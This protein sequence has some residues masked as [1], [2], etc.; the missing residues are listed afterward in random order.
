MWSPRLPAT[1]T[2]FFLTEH[3]MHPQPPLPSPWSLF[4]GPAQPSLCR[5]AARRHASGARPTIRI[6]HNTPPMTQPISHWTARDLQKV[7]KCFHCKYLLKSAIQGLAA[8]HINK[9]HI[10]KKRD[11]KM[12]PHQRKSKMP[13]K[14]GGKLSMLSGSGPQKSGSGSRQISTYMLCKRRR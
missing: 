13:T 5:S 1:P 8:K 11:N 12:P 4:R 3:P 10:Q 6:P 7:K 9:N 14:Q 2:T